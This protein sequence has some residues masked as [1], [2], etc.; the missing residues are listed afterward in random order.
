M[1]SF[2][3]A[4]SDHF[5]MSNESASEFARELKKLNDQD[6]ADFSRILTA[7]GVEHTPPAIK[8]AA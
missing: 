7:G 4:M 3:K 8:S 5:R 2:V 1:P 6:R